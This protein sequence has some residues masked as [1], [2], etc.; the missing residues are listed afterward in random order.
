MN[1]M[2]DI[3]EKM[4]LLEG[5]ASKPDFL[6]LDKDGDRKEPMKK[7][8]KEKKV[9]E[10]NGN[11]VPVTIDAEQ[12]FH[13][14][15]DKELLKDMINDAR[16]M[17]YDEFHDE[18]SRHLDDPHEFWEN[19]HDG[20][21]VAESD[22]NEAAAK[23][24][25]MA[26][27][28]KLCAR[29]AF[30]NID[31]KMFLKAA[32]LFAAGDE[33]RGLDAIER[34]DTEA[35]DDFYMGCDRAGIPV[36]MD[37]SALQAYL[38]KKK[39]GEAGMRALQQA[40]REGASKER[41]AAIRARHDKMDE[42]D[43]DEVAPPGLQAA[44]GS[45]G[46]ILGAGIGAALGGFAG[47]AATGAIFPGPEG[48]V[49][50]AVAGGIA[51]AVKGAG[52][53]GRLGRKATDFT[54]DQLV[55]LWRKASATL[56]GPTAT[57]DF[58]H[59]HANA[60]NEGEHSFNYQ[61]KNYAVTMDK[62]QA[63]QAMRDLDKM[64]GGDLGTR[65]VERE[66]QR[67]RDR[68]HD[69]KMIEADMAEGGN[70]FLD[71]RLAAIKAGK[72]T[73]SFGGKTFRVTG[74]TSDE[75][76]M[77]KK[78]KTLWPGTPEYKA[79]FGDEMRTGEKKRSSTGGEIEKTA[80]GVKHTKSYDDEEGDDAKT[81]DGAPKKRG[82]PKGKDKGPERVTAKAWKHKGGRVKED[83]DQ[84]EYDEEGEMA[85]SQSRTI[86]DAAEELQSMLGDNENLP[87]WVQKK[88]S[89][90]Q[91]YIDSARDYL[92]A[93]RPD[94]DG[95][96]EMIP[97]RELTKPEM[98]KREKYVK[99]MKKSKGD[100]EKRY[101]DRGEEVMYATATKMAKKKAEESKDDKEEEIE[102]TTTS[103]SVATAPAEAPKGKK[104]MIFGK[105]VYE[106]YEEK[107]K[108][109]LTEGMSINMSV[110][111]DGTKSLNVNATDED[112]VKLAQ[113]LKLAG[114]EQAH[115]HAEACPSC[116][117]AACGCESLEEADY[118]NSPEETGADINTLVNTYSDG[119]DG[120]KTTGQTTI[121]VVAGQTQRMMSQVREQAEQRLWD[122]Y[123]RY[124]SK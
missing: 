84:D 82:R 108:R 1:N 89:L 47:S 76:M 31:R 107:Y 43:I 122:L 15:K 123:K 77:E 104:G 33:E 36:P 54:H 118:A 26:R 103:G 90:A 34:M 13:G 75:K 63:R 114:M 66:R 110:G 57:L 53:G 46:G 23:T 4:K 32:E 113:I 24:A 52:V 88:I 98:A 58:V 70:K 78:E 40:G 92:K 38:G 73:F 7:A 27:I 5:K 67:V 119:L 25:R 91:E 81:D 50:G 117:Q 49:P 30:S 111:E 48:A 12:T 87:E 60:A 59:A 121:P 9:D 29:D 14:I 11:M 101:G 19:Y 28:A 106:G 74:D 69:A 16:A 95:E 8:A 61:G 112:A 115:G 22:V 51:G 37:E 18:Y 41:M 10:S 56:G 6:D 68:Y 71:T 39:Y 109:L 64:T 2:Y 35:R 86:A 21:E 96:E 124:E 120:Q 42:A 83:Y 45:I 93:N 116:G 94:Q 17:D 99:S 97:E 65:A 55:N 20:E 62:Q 44:G 72:P 3:L 100:F 85:K 80:T 79:K 105:G 102:E